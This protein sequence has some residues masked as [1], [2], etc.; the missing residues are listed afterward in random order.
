VET[1]AGGFVGGGCA[2]G[3]RYA[4]DYHAKPHPFRWGLGRRHHIQLLR[5]IDKKKG[6]HKRIQIPLP[7]RG[8]K[9]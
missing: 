1:L 4:I 5:Y 2:G 6:S 7:G 3:V 9:R 8:P